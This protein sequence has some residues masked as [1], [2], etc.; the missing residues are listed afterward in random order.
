MATGLDFTY[1]YPFASYL[2]SEASNAGLVLATC[3]ARQEHPHFFCGRM[4][5]PRLVGEML[6]TL[7]EVVRT[8]YFLP[9]PA[10]LDPVVTSSPEMLRFE[11]F[12]VCCGVYAR[13][14]LPA[15]AFDREI[16]RSGTT[17]VD[18]NSAMRHA[19][20]RLRTSREASLSV[21]RDGVELT[22][23]GETVV[24]KKV[25]LPIRWL[26]GFSEVQAYQ[27]GLTLRVE[28][29]GTE[30]RRFVRSLPA[31]VGPKN[32]SYV[33]ASGN[34]LRLSQVSR[35]GAVPVQ[36]MNR[37]RAIEP[38]LAAARSL[39]IW[40]DDSGVSG[41]E[42]I[43]PTGRFFLLISPEL[44][45]GFSGE[46]QALAQ[47]ATGHWQ[48]A[49]PY[50]QAQ[51]AGQTQIDATALAAKLGLSIAEV[52]AALAVLGTR[53]LAGFDVASGRFFHRELPFQLD[54]IEALQPRL[55]EARKL[56]GEKQLRILATPEECAWDVSVP[57]TGVEHHVRLRAGGDRCTCQWYS[58]HQGERGPCKHILAARMFVEKD[59]GEDEA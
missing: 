9:R 26:K 11:G 43:F 55:K 56:L 37:I 22:H 52:N 8:H 5:E 14:D 41:W 57:G 31:G 39:R 42:V 40:S 59:T 27:A 3:T 32:I 21:G 25:K 15:A 2:G 54:Q 17:N 20:Q 50:V 12:S 38:L 16:Q 33:V 35:P 30:A 45:R 47:L 6:L 46:G 19:L 23:A 4:R 24:E 53:G 36:G 49:L 34:S 7:S 48:E 13:A 1:R 51:L 10:N 18:F 29:P 44:Q 28:V 58:K